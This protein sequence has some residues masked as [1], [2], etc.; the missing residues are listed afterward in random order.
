MPNSIIGID[1]TLL[2]HLEDSIRNASSIRMI[3]AFLMESG[4]RL[5]ADQLVAAARRGVG[6]KILTGTY[7]AVTEPSAIY[8][9][10]DKLGAKVEIRFFKSVFNF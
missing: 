1:N 9:L 3:I 6:I 7:L 2:T 5:I 8:Y 10:W 4:A